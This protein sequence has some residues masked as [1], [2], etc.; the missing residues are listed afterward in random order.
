MPRHPARIDVSG[1][2]R[3]QTGVDHHVEE[4]ETGRLPADQ[5]STLPPKTSGGM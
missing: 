1:V 5:P 4:P 3:R 2:D